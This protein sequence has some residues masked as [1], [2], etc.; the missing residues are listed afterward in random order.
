MASRR[1]ISAFATGAVTASLGTAAILSSAAS[2]NSQLKPITVQA[3]PA[4]PIEL[5]RAGWTLLHSVAASYPDRPSAAWQAAARDFV[6]SFSVL[7]PCRPCAFH[8]REYIREHPPDVRSRKALSDW[9]F[10]YH[11]AVNEIT[12]KPEVVLVDSSGRRISPVAAFGYPSTA[13]FDDISDL[14]DDPLPPPQAST[15]F[16]PYVPGTPQT[17]DARGS[18]AGAARQP[19]ASGFLPAWD[20]GDSSSIGGLFPGGGARGTSAPASDAKESARPAH[21]A[22]STA[23]LKEKMDQMRSGCEHWCVRTKE[24][25]H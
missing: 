3:T 11:N 14:A 25:V 20:S 18:S 5:G 24:K 4:S 9:I 17:S 21:R 10:K 19:A 8:M 6:Y 7:F 12:D 15:F 1:W 16:H 22:L 23:E 13:T 2:D